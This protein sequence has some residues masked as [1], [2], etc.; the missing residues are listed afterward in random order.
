MQAGRR[1]AHRSDDGQSTIEAQGGPDPRGSRGQ[2]VSDMDVL[3]EEE[4]SANSTAGFLLQLNRERKLYRN[5]LPGGSGPSAAV[6]N[7][8]SDFGESA[9]RSCDQGLPLPCNAS[10]LGIQ[11]KNWPALLTVVVIVVTIAGNILVILAVSLEKKLQS[12]MNYFLMSLAIA[13][14]L[15]GF[16]VMPVSMLTILYGE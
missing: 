16:L 12:A 5:V 1:G 6:C 2:H 14:M 8:T 15:L 3:Y 4:S 7:L 13:D 9:N 10:F 11:E